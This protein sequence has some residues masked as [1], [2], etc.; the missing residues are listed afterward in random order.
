AVATAVGR[1]HQGQAELAAALL[2]ERQAD[3][4]APVAGHEVDGLGRDEVR[5]EDQVALVLAV[6]LV[7]EDD[8]PAGAELLDEFGYRGDRH[9]RHSTMGDR[10]TPRHA[11]APDRPAVSLLRCTRAILGSWT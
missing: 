6:F 3:Q 4:A 10:P 8:H 1:H 5:R 9:D 7:H 2:R 11:G